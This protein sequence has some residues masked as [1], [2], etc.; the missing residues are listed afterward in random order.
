M[1]VKCIDNI[2]VADS[3]TV[4]RIYE[5]MS[6]TS[7]SYVV[8]GDAGYADAFHHRRFEI[9]D[10]SDEVPPTLPVPTRADIHATPQEK[11]EWM[12]SR[13]ATLH[14]NECFCG[15]SLPCDYH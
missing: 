12:V 1:K 11:P 13:S 3:L 14:K 15:H 10:E 9:I 6:D 7:S 5:V 8:R 4:G 2:N